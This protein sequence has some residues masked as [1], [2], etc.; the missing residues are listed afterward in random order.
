MD[1]TNNYL[2][3]S[4]LILIIIVNLGFGVKKAIKSVKSYLDKKEIDNE[5][6]DNINRFLNEE[7]IGDLNELI[8]EGVEYIV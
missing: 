4:L 1:D 7:N 3:I 6:L 2:Q 5:I 8:E